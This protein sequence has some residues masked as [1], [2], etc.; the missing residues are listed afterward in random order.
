M[1][2]MRINTLKGIQRCIRAARIRDLF[3][4]REQEC[5]L[6]MILLLLVCKNVFPKH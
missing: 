3:C 1:G 6:W 2:T 4:L 5:C